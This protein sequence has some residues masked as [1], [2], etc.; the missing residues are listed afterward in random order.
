M[1]SDAAVILESGEVRIFDVQHAGFSHQLNP[2]QLNAKGLYKIPRQDPPISLSTN[3]IQRTKKKLRIA[4]KERKPPTKVEGLPFEWWRCEFAWHPK[5]LLVAGSKEVS[6]MDFRVKF[7]GAYA[8]LGP[9]PK[10]SGD[11]AQDCHTSVVA[12]LPG[13][14]NSAGYGNRPS[15]D[16]AF[17][18]FARAD[19]DGM[20]QFATTTR[21][22]IMLFD[23]RRPH[24]PLLQV[25]SLSS[26]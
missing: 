25:A 4:M 14:A 15:V 1:P 21:R 19:H 20:Y 23:T 5:I 24:T 2:L 11:V 3:P 9:L 7:T 8:Q 18:S 26:R 16:D 13:C 6:L 10:E 12:R 22:H 17:S